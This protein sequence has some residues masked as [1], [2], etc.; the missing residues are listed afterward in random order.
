MTAKNGMGSLAITGL[1]ALMALPQTPKGKRRRSA[2]I[3]SPR[4]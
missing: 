3:R 1:V 2:W 4:P